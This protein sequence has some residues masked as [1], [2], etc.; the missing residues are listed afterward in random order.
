[1]HTK[2]RR[3]LT[4]LHKVLARRKVKNDPSP[5]C[6]QEANLDSQSSVSARH[7]GTPG[8]LA[9]RLPI[10]AVGVRK[11]ARRGWGGGGLMEGRSGGLLCGG[12]AD[13]CRDFANHRLHLGTY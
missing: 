11:S 3:A 1:M 7:Q 5:R 13:S 12:Y 10:K 4:N 2:T 6:V 8:S 9:L